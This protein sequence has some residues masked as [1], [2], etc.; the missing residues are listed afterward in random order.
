MKIKIF[1]FVENAGNCTG[2]LKH[3]FYIITDEKVREI[4]KA[5]HP[6]IS[7][8]L[9]ACPCCNKVVEST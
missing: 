5:K 3:K 7:F 8:P 6:E 2:D 9:W 1:T 4:I